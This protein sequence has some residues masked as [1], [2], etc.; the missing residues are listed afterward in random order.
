MPPFLGN[1]QQSPRRL[2]PVAWGFLDI[3][4]RSLTWASSTSSR[5]SVAAACCA[6]LDPAETNGV[7]SA[8]QPAALAS[9]LP[10]APPLPCVPQARA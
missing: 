8:R 6:S 7:S 3:R 5:Q 2:L 9:A 1:V 10:T 4:S